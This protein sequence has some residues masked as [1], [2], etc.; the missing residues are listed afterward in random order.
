MVF[1]VNRA[2][3]G[4]EHRTHKDTIFRPSFVGVLPDHPRINYTSLS[5]E[6]S[7]DE[8]ILDTES[9][10]LKYLTQEQIQEYRQLTRN[11]HG[12]KGRGPPRALNNIDSLNDVDF[13][14]NNLSMA[15]QDYLQRYNLVS[16]K[17][18]TNPTRNG[19]RDVI[20][21]QPPEQREEGHHVSG[22]QAFEK[23]RDG[24]VASIQCSA[25]PSTPEPRQTEPILDIQRLRNLP[26]LLQSRK[27]V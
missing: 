10:A 21:T 14:W 25:P 4:K 15:T 16:G 2:E 22:T 18:T 11:R 3:P 17:K 9:L 1:F 26:K 12:N 23:S 24:S 19:A 8:T 7:L 27:I 5:V 13:T 6:E 20:G